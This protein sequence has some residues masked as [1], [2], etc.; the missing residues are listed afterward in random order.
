MP[1]GSFARK[2]ETE[3]RH[4]RGNVTRGIIRG[5]RSLSLSGH[6]GAENRR[7][8]VSGIIHAELRCYLDADVEIRSYLLQTRIRKL[9]RQPPSVNRCILEESADGL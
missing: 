6:F 5:I 1:R 9:S 2:K 4:L 8:S 3:K 7:I